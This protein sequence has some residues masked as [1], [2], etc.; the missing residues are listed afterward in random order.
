MKV[1]QVHNFYQQPGGEDQ[2]CAAEHDLLTKRGHSVQQYCTHNEVINGMSN[3]GVACRTIWNAGSYREFKAALN[4]ER[5]DIVHVHNTFPVI[6]PAIYYA[7]AKAEIPVVQTLH[8]YRLLW[9]SATLFRN[10]NI[11]EKCIGVPIPI[12]SVRHACYRD[13]RLASAAVSSM[14]VM[15]RLART[16]ATKIQAYIALT[17]FAKRKFI[18][19]GLP[20]RRIVVKPNFLSTDP[21]VGNGSGRYALFQGRLSSE[22]GLDTLLNAWERLAP[23]VELK[24]AGDGPLGPWLKERLSRLRNVEW[25]GY[26]N[27]DKLLNLT[28]DA[29]FL[30][31]PS[32]C[33]E[34]LPMGI[35]EALACGTPVLASALGSPNELIRDGVN[36]FRFAPGNDDDLVRCIQSILSRPDELREMRRSSRACYEQYYTADRNY[37]LLMGVYQKAIAAEHV[38]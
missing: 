12:M 10:G 22:K 32:L 6:S 1:L 5:P 24:I 23:T 15:H 14:L 13:N 8:N 29:A 9:P 34:G 20:P 3:I 30:V 31:F 4:R 18:E 37:E 36:G 26:V 33:Y 27:R 21:G 2:V 35:I 28:K 38:C 25:L 7:A 17:N 16:W 19:G 11:C